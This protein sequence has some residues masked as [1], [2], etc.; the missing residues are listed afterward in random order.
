MQKHFANAKIFES[1][2]F[3][4]SIKT[5]KSSRIETVLLYYQSWK[6]KL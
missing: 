5:L 2:N 4:E 1:I 3:R 6:L